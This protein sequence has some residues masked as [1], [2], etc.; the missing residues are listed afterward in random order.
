MKKALQF[1]RQALPNQGAA[2]PVVY[3]VHW[4]SQCGRYRVRESHL[5]S[6]VRYYAQVLV[7]GCWDV[8][9]THRKRGAAVQACA[10]HA[11]RDPC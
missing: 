5:G 6:S 10:R 11:R 3:G 7:G 9:S 1:R 4:D 2:A 8:I